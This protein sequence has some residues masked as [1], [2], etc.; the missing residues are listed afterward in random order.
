MKIKPLFDRVIVEAKQENSSASGI[1]VGT[2][3]QDK[4]QIGTVLFAGEGNQTDDG[5][6][7]PM[8]VK[9][10]DSILFNK[11]SGV[12]AVIDGKSVY[13]LRQTD[14]LAIIE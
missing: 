3:N 2:T 10:G 5:K 7:L 9:V 6:Q 13:I 8:F 4:P 12:E 11:F 1:F 14:I